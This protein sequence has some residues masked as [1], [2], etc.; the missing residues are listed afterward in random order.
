MRSRA[1]G[2]RCDVGARAEGEEASDDENE[3]TVVGR[4]RGKGNGW[5]CLEKMVWGDTHWDHSG[6]GD[7]LEIVPNGCIFAWTSIRD[8]IKNLWHPGIS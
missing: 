6:E 3:D 8:G 4:G 2:T 5:V 1:E 7:R